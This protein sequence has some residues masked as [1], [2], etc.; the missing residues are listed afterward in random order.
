MHPALVSEA[1]FVAVQGL[2]A[3]RED[4]RH[5]YALAGLLRCV[6]CDRAFEGHWVHNTPGYR[7]RHGHTSA[8]NTDPD[9][10]KN[11]YLGVGRVLVA[12]TTA[13]PNTRVPA[14]KRVRIGGTVQGVPHSAVGCAPSGEA[15]VDPAPGLQR[16][17]C[18]LKHA[19]WVDHWRGGCA[20]R[21]WPCRRGRR[22][23]GG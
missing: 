1:D 13:S 5:K 9:R 21:G 16:L 20:G 17:R 3:V 19:K 18:C 4:A 11:A 7:C 22:R 23:G 12:M 6:I 15:R 10:Q 2:R 8:R 14:A